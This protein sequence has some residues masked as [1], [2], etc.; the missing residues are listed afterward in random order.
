MSGVREG[1]RSAIRNRLSA[2]FNGRSEPR[3][4][5]PTI[6]PTSGHKLRSHR[7]EQ[8]QLDLSQ[9]NLSVPSL[10][11]PNS[12]RSIIDPRSSSTHNRHSAAPMPL[13]ASSP[14]PSQAYSSVTLRPATNELANDPFASIAVTE[15]SPAPKRRNRR[16]RR[17]FPYIRNKAL[18]RKAITCVVSGSLLA[19]ILIICTDCHSPPVFAIRAY[20]NIVADLALAVQDIIASEIFHIVLILSIL[21]LAT[22]FCH[23][24][25]RLCMLVYSPLSGQ[26]GSQSSVRESGE[27]FTHPVEPI[28]VVLA[29]DEELGLVGSGGAEVAET[30]EPKP[31]PPVY[32][33]WR[34]SVVRNPGCASFVV[35]LLM[36]SNSEPTQ[37]YFIGNLS[38]I[39]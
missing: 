22:F 19:L 18:R 38:I 13:E 23:Q 36:I 30:K 1:T 16:Q 39:R 10:R 11:S 9:L 2:F 26:G 27:S 15:D 35:L 14:R 6:R 4:I 33:L 20:T 32:G 3:T 17:R 37:T 5:L 31:P 8:L 7:R 21:A 24:L 12:T 34:G 29:R 25:I 28:P